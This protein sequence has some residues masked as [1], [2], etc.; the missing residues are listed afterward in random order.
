M[1]S[2]SQFRINVKR[3]AERR[4]DGKGAGENMAESSLLSLTATL[5]GSSC[6]LAAESEVE[7]RV[8][9]GLWKGCAGVREFASVLSSSV[10]GPEGGFIG[11]RKPE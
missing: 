8:I 4:L 10:M 9:P 6:E 1:A 7:L 5:Q 11:D 2:V 3:R